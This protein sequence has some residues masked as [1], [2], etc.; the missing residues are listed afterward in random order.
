MN[1]LSL[2]TKDERKLDTRNYIKVDEHGGSLRG[3]FHSSQLP[4][5][6]V[7]FQSIGCI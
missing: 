1:N 7:H 6:F 4:S 5:L 2:S 3:V